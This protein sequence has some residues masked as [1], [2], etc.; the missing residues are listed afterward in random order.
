MCL[1]LSLFAC[2]VKYYF[3]HSQKKAL[4]ISGAYHQARMGEQG[5]KGC[6]G[7]HSVVTK[8]DKILII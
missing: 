2:K 6:C 3:R 4:E 5:K 8:I 1:W 7:C